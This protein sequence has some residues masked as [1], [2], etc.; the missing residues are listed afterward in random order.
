MKPEQELPLIISEK[1]QIMKSK[2]IMEQDQKKLNINNKK[3]WI[4]VSN[5]KAEINTKLK[6]S[7]E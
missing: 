1:I 3:C 2:S 4:I 5:A 7:D 6:D